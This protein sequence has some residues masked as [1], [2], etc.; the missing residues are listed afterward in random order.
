MAVETF[1]QEKL[2]W[3]QKL[4]QNRIGIVGQ[5]RSPRILTEL[6]K[7]NNKFQN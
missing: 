4:T 5:E 2:F 3:I 1:S 6:C 7:I